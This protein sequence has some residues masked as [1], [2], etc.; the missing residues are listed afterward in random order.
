M[1]FQMHCEDPAVR[2]IQS[3]QGAPIC[4]REIAFRSEFHPSWRTNANVK[5]RRQAISVIC[6][7][8]SRSRAPAVFAALHAMNDA[9]GP[10]PREPPIPFH[11]AVKGEHLA[12]GTK[13]EI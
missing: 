12:L 13:R 4:L 9:R 3:I 1:R 11:I 8:F 5:N 6:G 2:P 7:P 10:I